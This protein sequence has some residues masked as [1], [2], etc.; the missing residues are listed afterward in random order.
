M[1]HLGGFA[2]ALHAIAT[3]VLAV[4]QVCLYKRLVPYVRFKAKEAEHQLKSLENAEEKALAEAY[5]RASAKQSKRRRR[6]AGDDPPLI[7]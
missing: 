1:E 3:G 4:V 6:P 7:P 5:Q 2:T